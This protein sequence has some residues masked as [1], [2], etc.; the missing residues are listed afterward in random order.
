MSKRDQLR[1]FNLLSKQITD[2][3]PLSDSQLSYLAEVFS[4]ISQGENA[5]EVLGLSRQRGQKDADEIA[6]QRM[7]MILHWI[8][9]A[10]HPDPAADGEKA[11][12]IEEACVSAQTTIVP[13][14]KH[15]FP[16]DDGKT[17]N[18]EY[19][20][21]CWGEPRYKHLRSTRRGTYDADYPY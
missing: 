20:I 7:S 1:I 3:D 12:S 2:G 15:A 6:R 16:G 18:V 4:R 19:L 11:M 21:R 5:N 10:V 9:C 17:Y 13:A 8:A 14:A